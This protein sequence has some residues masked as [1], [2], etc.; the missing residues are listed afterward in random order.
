MLIVL[1]VYSSHLDLQILNRSRERPYLA[2]FPMVGMGAALLLLFGARDRRD[3]RPFI[4]MSAGGAAA[5]AIVREKGSMYGRNDTIK[6][7]K[8]AI[9]ATETG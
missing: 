1:F 7:P 3:F 9:K 2:A 6:V 5:S 4:L 8:A